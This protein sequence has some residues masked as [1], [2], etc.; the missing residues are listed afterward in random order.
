MSPM[1]WMRQSQTWWARFDH[2]LEVGRNCHGAA[3]IWN[4]TRLG[5][6]Y[7][8]SDISHSLISASQQ[9]LTQCCCAA[10]FGKSPTDHMDIMRGN[11]SLSWFLTLDK[12][13]TLHLLSSK[14]F[15]LSMVDIKSHHYEYLIT[16][17]SW[18]TSSHSANHYTSAHARELN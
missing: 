17:I 5:M 6:W 16:S 14:W 10:L 2:G 7:Y 12:E 1:E 11:Q 9:M 4:V 8:L 18:S 13:P 15:Q 3:F